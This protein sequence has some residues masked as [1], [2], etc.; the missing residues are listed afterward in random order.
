MSKNQLV[1]FIISHR[2]LTDSHSRMFEKQQLIKY[3]AINGGWSGYPELKWNREKLEQLSDECLC[4]IVK[5]VGVK[6][7]EVITINPGV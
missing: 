1:D 5:R 4:R 7:V 2:S 3:E 6:T